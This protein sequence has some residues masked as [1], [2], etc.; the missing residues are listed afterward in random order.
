MNDTLSAVISRKQ[1]LLFDLFHTLTAV[2]PVDS[3]EPTTAALLG[4]DR[5]AWHEQLMEKSR[6]RLAGQETDP[7][8]ILRRMAHAID[9]SI[10]LE[11]IQ[12]AAEN[13]MA[14]FAKTVVNMPEET[15]RVLRSLKDRGKKLGL[16]SNADVTEIVAWNESPVA[17]LFDSVVFSCHVGCVK[18]EREIYETSMR[19]LR[20]RAAD[21]VFVGDGGCS[22][23]EGARNVGL[24]TVMMTGVIRE[25]W[26][27]KI[28]ERKIHADFVI[29]TLGDLL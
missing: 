24:T 21:C 17:A 2:Q 19:G 7:V 29:E 26:P 13:R 23:L 16:V 11:V 6:E 20:A 14:R 28:A 9:P 18:P 22:E 8:T 25:T 5:A 27:D 15:V 12:K 10:P 1:A 4:V 3:R